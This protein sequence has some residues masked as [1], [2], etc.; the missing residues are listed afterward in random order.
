MNRPLIIVKSKIPLSSKQREAVEAQVKAKA[1]DVNVLVVSGL[2][3]D[4][5]V[6]APYVFEERLGDYYWKAGVQT[7]KE[8]IEVAGE[9]VGL[10][11]TY[12]RGE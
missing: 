10:A 7:I 2:E 4:V 9:C 5:E 8:L 11:E 12:G 6:V 3:V 1:G